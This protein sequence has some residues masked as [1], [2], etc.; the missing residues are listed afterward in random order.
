MRTITIALGLGG[1]ILVGA[2]DADAHKRREVCRGGND[3]DWSALIGSGSTCVRRHRH[4]P[5]YYDHGHHY[6][7]HGRG[8][9]YTVEHFRVRDPRAEDVERYGRS[10]GRVYDYEERLHGY[11]RHERECQPLVTVK[12]AEAQTEDG[13]LKVAKRAWRATV[14][15]DYGEVYQDLN[16][17]RDRFRQKGAEYRCWRSST[18]ETAI[19]KIG[20]F[21]PGAYRKRCQI[22]AVPCMGKRFKL[23]SDQDDRE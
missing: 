16:E 15:A 13:A 17:A 22:W 2:S 14:R 12:G 7:H 3:S 20:E 18:N 6:D 4:R 8:R 10:R 9:H 21:F 23:E 19:G 11:G 5:R 1:M